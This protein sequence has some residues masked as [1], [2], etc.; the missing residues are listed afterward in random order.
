MDNWIKVVVLVVV[1][2]RVFRYEGYF[3]TVATVHCRVIRNR[4]GPKEISIVVQRLANVAIH[5]PRYLQCA[6]SAPI[7]GRSGA[8]DSVHEQSESERS[9]SYKKNAVKICC[10][11]P[12]VRNHRN[13]NCCKHEPR[14]NAKCRNESVICPNCQVELLSFSLNLPEK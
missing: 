6:P 4:V 10:T 8:A 1:M 11:E 3:C 12:I 14:Q 13:S 5:S 9:T 2:I 7:L